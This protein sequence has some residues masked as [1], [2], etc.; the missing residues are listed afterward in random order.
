MFKILKLIFG[1]KNLRGNFKIILLKFEKIVED[2]IVKLR[3]TT[4]E[5]NTNQK[6]KIKIEDLHLLLVV[7][8]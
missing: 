6:E 3:Q 4:T 7:A 1:R 2:D 5:S 8:R